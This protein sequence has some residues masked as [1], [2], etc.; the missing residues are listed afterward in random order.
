MAGQSAV[1]TVE[2]FRFFRDLSRNN[3]KEWMDANRERYRAHVVEPFRVL[4]DRLG[5]AVLRL[6]P[7]FDVSGRTGTNFSRINRDI[8][9]ARDKSPYRP[10]MYL[11]FA[12]ER[13]QAG[14]AEAVRAGDG[15]LYVGLSA[16]A[17]TVGVRIYGDRKSWLGRMAAPR[18]SAHARWL[19][20]QARRLRRQYESYW[21][22]TE[23]GDWKKNRGWP[24]RPEDWQR[25]R[26][27]IV[28]RKLRPAAATRGDFP[29]QVSRV[30]RELLPLYRFI[31]S[32][33]WKL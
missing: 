12:D 31:S 23:K 17:V 9:F 28:R 14:P 24:V 5:P 3:R 13:A 4:L 6:N 1:F 16:D 22:S 26:G 21:Y 27:W 18:A 2:T 15:Q 25:I 20:R 10:Q 19:E 30:F 8:R 32:A 33:D 11:L 7:R 29:G